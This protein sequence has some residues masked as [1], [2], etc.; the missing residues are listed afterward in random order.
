MSV[1]IKNSSQVNTNKSKLG[2]TIGDGAYPKI[3]LNRIQVV[4]RPAEGEEHTKLFFNPRFLESF[5]NESMKDLRQSIQEIG[6]LQPL[7]VR[8]V[9][10]GDEISKVDLIGGERRLRCLL[11]LVENDEEVFSK[12]LGQMVL[13]SELYSEV[14]C[15]IHYDIDDEL[16]LRLACDENGKSKNITDAE[17]IALVERLAS[18]KL[19]TS[20][21][22]KITG[23]NSPSW[24]SHTVNFRSKLP[25]Q[26]FDLL[27]EGKL[28]RSVAI[29]IMSY[30]E[31]E[32]EI[33]LKA[34]IQAEE[35]ATNLKL[36]QAEDLIA[37]AD[38]TVQLAERKR[39]KAEKSG[40][41]TTALKAEKAK[42]AAEKKKEKATEKKGKIES[43]AGS[44][45][46]GDVE[47][48]AKKAKV[49]PKTPKLMSKHDINSCIIDP[50]N[51]W[52]N[53]GYT[54]PVYDC[55]VS[56]EMLMI[57]GS[58]ANSFAEGERDPA[59]IIRKAMIES[60]QWASADNV[61]DDPD[62]D[63]DD[64]D[65]DIV[66]DDEVVDGLDDNFDDD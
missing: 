54:D 57:V 19:S 8:V 39:L 23:Q 40:D 4:E 55:Q 59:A 16:A 21:I 9:M 51:E 17:E 64:D 52:I 32:R 37:E 24:V 46:Q 12:E 29:K 13:A 42:K 35:E 6:L 48:G 44:I 56:E 63:D 53:D 41:A 30:P 38:D 10:D 45:S 20:E 60:N 18:R 34:T 1:S 28:S 31:E 58:I 47:I 7:I 62:D 36:S 66:D 26:A 50:I 2:I 11:H 27:L 25:K 14:A 49:S 5:D 22:M 61:D 65:D 33:L 3:P 15:C 43:Q